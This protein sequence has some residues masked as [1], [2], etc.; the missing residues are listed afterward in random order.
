MKSKDDQETS[1]TES[2]PRPARL[3]K[4]LLRALDACSA[5]LQRLRNRIEPPLEES[6]RDR[7]RH[8]GAPAAEAAAPP[9]PKGLLRRTLV[10]LLC[11]L[12]GGNVGMLF[13]YRLLSRS[14]DARAGVIDFLQE[15]IGDWQREDARNRKSLAKCQ[16]ESGAHWKAAHEAQRQVEAGKEK[17]DELEKRLASVKPVERPVAAPAARTPAGRP[18]SAATARPLKSGDCTTGATNAAE[19]L[20]KCLDQFNR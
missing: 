11:L 3:K 10:V 2:E 5:G 20:A 18:S 12:I 9:R 6:L 13:S 16:E 14:L 4:A 17:I 19:N 1:A 8:N 15:R 7:G